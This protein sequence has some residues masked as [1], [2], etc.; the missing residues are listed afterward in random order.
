MSL[1]KSLRLVL[2]AAFA[3][4][5]MGACSQ[6]VSTATQ[7]VTVT[8][9]PDQQ[10]LTPCA[11]VWATQQLPDVSGQI[12]SGLAAAGLSDATARTEAFG[13]NCVEGDGTVRSFGAMETDFYLQ[14]PVS[15]LSDRSTLG[16]QLEKALA[17]LDQFPP[18]TVPG[19]QPGYIGV[20]F[21]AGQDTLN[22][23][24]TV[25]AGKSARDQGLHGADLVA[26][27]SN[28]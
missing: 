3:A 22:L 19:P 7:D 24:F 13:E 20:E 8:N 27:L 26:A 15:D 28:K 23:R 17:V 6:P 25:S 2:Y 18:G 21:S 5:I 11:F 16:D 14:L 1:G 10:Q 9:S 4:L 12:K